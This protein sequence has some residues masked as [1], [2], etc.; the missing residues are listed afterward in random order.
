VNA[1]RQ[2]SQSLGAWFAQVPGLKVVTPSTPRDVLG[3]FKSAIRDDN[4]VLCLFAKRLIGSSGEVPE[5][6]EDFTLPIG[7]SEV[8]RT[9]SDITIVGV[10]TMVRAAL[11]AAGSLSEENGIEAEVIDVMSLSPLDSD[12]IIASVKR[13]GRLCIVHEAHAPCGIGA[14]IIAR[15]SEQAH[16]VL[17]SPPLRITPPF[18]PSPFAPV[19]EKAY[20]PNAGR[21]A[22]EIRALLA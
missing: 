3:L 1:G 10:S 22:D 15:V 20:L 5:D 7:S 12:T 11:S 9:G 2:H 13:T 6:G 21:I 8:R 17:Q 16:G 4:P 19:L 18:A 14:E